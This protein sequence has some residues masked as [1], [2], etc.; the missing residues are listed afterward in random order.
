VLGKEKKFRR[1]QKRRG[2]SYPKAH[3]LGDVLVA[4]A[5]GDRRKER[6]MLQP[7]NAGNA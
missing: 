2:A 5:V 7:F 4:A 6:K 1:E 3:V